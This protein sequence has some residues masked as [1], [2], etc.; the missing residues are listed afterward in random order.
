MQRLGHPGP[1]HPFQRGHDRV[2]SGIDVPGPGSQLRRDGLAHAAVDAH[3]AM[4][5]ALGDGQEHRR[6]VEQGQQ[7]VPLALVF[8]VDLRQGLPHAAALLGVPREQRQQVLARHGRADIVSQSRHRQPASEP[9]KS[10]DRL[11]RARPR[12][13]VPGWHPGSRTTGSSA[14][15]GRRRWSR[16]RASIDWLCTPR[17]DSDACF[18]ALLGYDEHGRWSLR[19]TVPV[20]ETRQRYRDDTLIL[21]TEFHCD[22]GAVRVLDFMPIGTDDRTDVVRVLEGLEG[23]VTVE[24]MHGHPLR[25]RRRDAVAA[26]AVRTACRSPRGR[27]A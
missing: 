13:T 23:E 12:R 11:V 9:A 8:A 19:P 3:A 16:A 27:T 15:P 2:V 17:F 26:A 1:V 21:E 25:L 5:R 10:T 4:L 7:L 24:M 14:T 22:G 18:A 6:L 20:R